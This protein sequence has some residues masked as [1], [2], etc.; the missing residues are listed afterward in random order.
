[1]PGTTSTAGN[2]SGCYL[3]PRRL[4]AIT[5]MFNTMLSF[6]MTYLSAEC[7]RSTAYIWFPD[8]FHRLALGCVAGCLMCWSAGLDQV[9]IHNIFSLNQ[10][11]I[12]III[13]ITSSFNR[14]VWQPQA[15]Y[16]QYFIHSVNNANS[17]C[18]ETVV[19]VTSNSLYIASL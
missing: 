17:C 11:D 9:T 4:Q 5:L 15:I 12:I 18:G 3:M 2:C 6:T 14:M 7:Q 8:I 10:S 13:I 16:I 1:M 19:A